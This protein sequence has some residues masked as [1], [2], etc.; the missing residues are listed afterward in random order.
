MGRPD[1]S[2]VIRL[3]TLGMLIGKHRSIFYAEILSRSDCANLVR[4]L[5]S[6]DS[7]G[8]HSVFPTFI[9]ANSLVRLGF[10]NV[11]DALHLDE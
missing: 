11:G 1:W 9:A 5:G 7:L 8:S 4:D 2:M 6:V 3:E 10:G